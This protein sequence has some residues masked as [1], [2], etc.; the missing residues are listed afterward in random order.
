MLSHTIFILVSHTGEYT[1]NY[2]IITSLNKIFLVPFRDI[3]SRHWWI[4]LY[5]I[6]M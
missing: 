3:Q 5:R 4:R 6:I 1:A 2:S